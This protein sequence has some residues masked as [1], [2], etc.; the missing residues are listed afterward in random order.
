M[1]HIRPQ[2]IHHPKNTWNMYLFT[3]P[4]REES[5]YI[6]VPTIGC[7]LLFKFELEISVLEKK[8]RSNHI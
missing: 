7:A 8:D 6:T 5:K 4:T 3:L 1:E 2:L